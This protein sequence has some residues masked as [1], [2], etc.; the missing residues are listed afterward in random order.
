MAAE[1]MTAVRE[2]IIAETPEERAAVGFAELVLRGVAAVRAGWTAIGG[3]PDSS[4]T[5]G[6][7]P[8]GVFAS[9]GKARRR[10]AGSSS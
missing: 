10:L 2:I 3:S 6:A 4:D 8:S 9:W 7:A 5:P 1:R